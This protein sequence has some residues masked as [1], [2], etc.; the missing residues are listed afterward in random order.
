MIVMPCAV[1]LKQQLDASRQTACQ[2]DSYPR[3]SFVV[4]QAGL[5]YAHRTAAA[6]TIYKQHALAWPNATAFKNRP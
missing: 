6:Y 2:K 3:V 5:V 4:P 1:F